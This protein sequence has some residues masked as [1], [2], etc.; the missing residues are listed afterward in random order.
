[1]WHWRWLQIWYGFHRLYIMKGNGNSVVI[2]TEL[3]KPPTAWD[4]HDNEPHLTLRQLLRPSLISMAI[5]GCYTYDGNSTRTGR[6]TNQ[7]RPYRLFGTLYRIVF[8][9]VCVLACVKSCAAFATLPSSSLH[10]NAI[11]TGWSIQCFLVFLISLKSDHSSYGGRNKAFDFWDDKIRPDLDDL[12]IQFPEKTIK[13]R[14]AVYLI[15]ATCLFVFN[16]AGSAV[17]SADIFADGYGMFFAAPFTKSVTTLT[18][19]ML[20]LTVQTLIWIFPMFYIILISTLL[21]QTFE[22]FNDFLEKHIANNVIKMTC[23]FH[24]IRVLHLNLSKMVSELDRDFGYYYAVVFVL[25]IGLACF[26]LY[27]ILKTSMATIDLV[28]YLFWML[29]CLAFLGAVSVFAALVN[30]EVSTMNCYYNDS[31]WPQKYCY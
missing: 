22:A 3:E 6:E 21:I 16:L 12:G 27:Q 8:L 24:K 30:E 14:Q 23:K 11:V 25:S 29:S 13:K 18:V 1:M 28:M 4:D 31:I 7:G 15:L 19:A 26:I 5:S 2:N 17:L 20:I 10:F 9:M